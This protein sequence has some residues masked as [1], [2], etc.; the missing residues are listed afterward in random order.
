MGFHNLVKTTTIISAFLILLFPYLIHPF[1]G[2]MNADYASLGRG[3]S[4]A[5][6]IRD[7][8]LVAVTA[9]GLS[10][11]EVGD[12]LAVRL[13]GLRI[14]HRLVE[15]IDGEPPRLRLKGDGNERSDPIL[16][17]ESQIMGKVVAV[18]HLNGIYTPSYGYVISL[19]A[20][21]LL[22]ISLRRSSKIDVNDVLLC[23]I[24]ALSLGGIIGYILIGGASH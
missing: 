24:I 11:V 17:E 18:Y 13:G 15:I 2:I 6:T 5:P 22:L 23:L 12:I 16:F 21:T 1:P 8:D 7:G 19:T 4:M 9:A 20:A 3:P 14:V 10:D